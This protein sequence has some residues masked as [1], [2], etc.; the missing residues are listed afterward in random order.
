MHVC[1]C[2]GQYGLV[3]SICTPC[4]PKYRVAVA[5]VMGHNLNAIVCDTTQT[6]C[7]AIAHLKT[8]KYAPHTFLPVDGLHNTASVDEVDRYDQR[9]LCTPPVQL[10]Y[11]VVTTSFSV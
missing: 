4:D 1:V 11:P 5:K 8:H 2:N 10:M 7:L 6:A 3:M 9:L